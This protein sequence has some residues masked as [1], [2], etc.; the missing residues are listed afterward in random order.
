MPKC[1]NCDT[2]VSPDAFNCSTCGAQ[3]SQAKPTY[4]GAE[5]SKT[6]VG[7]SDSW[8][9]VITKVVGVV[10]V[11]LV[12]LLLVLPIIANMWIAS[13]QKEITSEAEQQIMDSFQQGTL[14]IV[15]AYECEDDI[16]GCKNL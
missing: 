15:S 3:V 10:V 7:R 16:P 13:V 4:L 6:S 5:Q 9:G 2:E 1:P 8:T 14:Q 11:G 12:F